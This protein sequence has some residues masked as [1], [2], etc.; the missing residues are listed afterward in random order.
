MIQLQQQILSKTQ[1]GIK[2][3]IVDGTSIS[4]T[5]KPSISQLS[6]ANNLLRSP[7]VEENNLSYDEVKALSDEYHISCKNIYEMHSEFNSMREIAIQEIQFDLKD[8]RPQ[9]NNEEQESMEIIIAESKTQGIPLSFFTK[10]S[11][12]MN[13]K[14]REIQE[15]MLEAFGIH[16]QNT[17]MNHYISWGLFLRMNAL[18]NYHCATKEE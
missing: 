16:V 6:S 13:D 11:P 15:P 14:H 2:A 4:R 17:K 10:N 7:P 18:L 12:L 8:R 1:A 3:H 5:N 9:T